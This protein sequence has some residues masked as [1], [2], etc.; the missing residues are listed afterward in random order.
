MRITAVVSPC[1]NRDKDF[2]M[3][4]KHTFREHADYSRPLSA[5]EI[6]LASLVGFWKLRQILM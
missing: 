1:S 4:V 5:E 3:F 2:N 6:I